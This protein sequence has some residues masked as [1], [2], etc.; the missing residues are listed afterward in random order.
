MTSSSLLRAPAK[1][2]TAT[3]RQWLKLHEHELPK[4]SDGRDSTNI[5]PYAYFS[6]SIIRVE[7]KEHDDLDTDDYSREIDEAENRD[8]APED[9]CETIESSI[10]A[11]CDESE[12]EPEL[13]YDFESNSEFI[14][15]YFEVTTL[16]VPSTFTERL[17]EAIAEYSNSKAKREMLVD[18]SSGDLG[19]SWSRVE[20]CKFLYRDGR[21]I[22]HRGNRVKPPKFIYKRWT[23]MCRDAMTGKIVQRIEARFDSPEMR[24][25]DSLRRQMSNKADIKY[26]MKDW[27]AARFDALIDEVI[28]TVT[29]SYPVGPVRKFTRDILRAIRGMSWKRASAY[30][31]QHVPEYVEWL[32]DGEWA[33]LD[34][35]TSAANCD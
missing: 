3:D 17:N 25:L 2:F 26:T 20:Q 16:E 1:M 19:S 35:Q 4:E 28:P 24:V 31:A 27:D 12:Y 21:R 5:Q 18:S 29:V 14:E 6:D 32:E 13:H 33:L 22:Q 34:R 15:S 7:E 11:L 30:C 23:R 9:A 10:A 8:A